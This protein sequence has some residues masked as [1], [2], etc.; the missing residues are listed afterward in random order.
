M[1][2]GATGDASGVETITQALRASTR[3]VQGAMRAVH[4]ATSTESGEFPRH[5]ERIEIASV[6]SDCI[7]A[8][9]P[10]SA[11]KGIAL[12]VDAENAPALL[13][14]RVLT[15]QVFLGLLSQALNE[16]GSG[17]TVCL[18]VV[19]RTL[20]CEI[21]VGYTPCAATSA[22]AESVR[23]VPDIVRILIEAQG[24][25]VSTDS[26]AD[27]VRWTRLKYPLHRIANREVAL[28][29]AGGRAP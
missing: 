4:S 28:A 12:R 25:T 18:R 21:G 26:D 23:T 6:V 19:P 15:E 16:A 24:G 13:A 11:A 20:I 29:S 14:D 1:E 27:G 10:Q 3:I 5:E 8:L 7:A 2:S 22:G 9:R 17:D